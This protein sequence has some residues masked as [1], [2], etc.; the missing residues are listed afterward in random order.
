MDRQQYLNILAAEIRRVYNTEPT[1]FASAIVWLPSSSRFS[2]HDSVEI[3]SVEPVHSARRVY[4]WMRNG[5]SGQSS[6]VVT[7][8]GVPPIESSLDAVRAYLQR[9]PGMPCHSDAIGGN[10]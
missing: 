10:P 4:A 9:E 5:L 6:H 3:F 1:H 8:L 2:D 7:V